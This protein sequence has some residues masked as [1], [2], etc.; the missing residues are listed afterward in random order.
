MGLGNKVT[1]E[2]IEAI[3]SAL[4]GEFCPACDDCCVLP[5]DDAAGVLRAMLEE[6]KRE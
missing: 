5:P 3:A 1:E 6:V 2:R 4:E